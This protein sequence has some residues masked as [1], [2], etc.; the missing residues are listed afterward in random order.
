MPHI[1]AYNSALSF[2]SIG[3][4]VDDALIDRSCGI[5]TFRIHGSMYHRLGSL[6]PEPGQ[7][8][9]FAQL[10]FYDTNH[11]VDN[12]LHHLNTLDRNT[13]VLLQQMIQ[14]QNRLYGLFKQAL[15]EETLASN[16]DGNHDVELPGHN[17]AMHILDQPELDNRRYNAPSS[18]EVAVILPDEGSGNRDIRVL[19]CAGAIQSISEL[20]P[21]Y[22]P[23]AYVLLFPTGSQE[24]GILA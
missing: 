11:E 19:L 18:S 14:N 10:Y 8:P 22:S 12:R 15:D 20:H 16:T 3:A 21:D 23:L 7:H 17:V 2:A 4:N 13:L 5:Y 6:L 9:A 1:R 24:A